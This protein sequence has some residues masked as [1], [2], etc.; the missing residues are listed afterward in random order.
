[1]MKTH[2][3]NQISQ[4]LLLTVTGLAVA[5]T[6]LAAE[7]E[8]SDLTTQSNPIELAEVALEAPEALE[9]TD[10]TSEPLL[11]L[12]EISSGVGNISDD[13]M[14]QMGEN[15][16]VTS[17][18]LATSVTGNSL[19]LSGTG[20]NTLDANIQVSGS[21]NFNSMYGVNTVAMNSGVAGVQNINISV[22]GNIEMAPS[23]ATP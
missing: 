20:P 4:V 1:M 18:A 9:A 23:T 6:A 7:G 16:A 10:G 2:R 8:N 3:R 17:L 11:D 13:I 19:N 22:G 5:G 14:I 15:G 12:S 21:S